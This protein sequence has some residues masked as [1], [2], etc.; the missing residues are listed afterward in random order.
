MAACRK[1]QTH[2]P[3]SGRWRARRGCSRSGRAKYSSDLFAIDDLDAYAHAVGLIHDRKRTGL[4]DHE[5]KVR[6]Q[7]ADHDTSSRGSYTSV[8]VYFD[9][10][11]AIRDLRVFADQM[12]ARQGWDVAT[13]GGWGGS[14]DR[15]TVRVRRRSLTS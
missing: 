15:F 10:G 3:T 11:C 14:G 1:G 2:R 8:V 5:H 9:C 4:A 6:W 7:P 12:R 13:S